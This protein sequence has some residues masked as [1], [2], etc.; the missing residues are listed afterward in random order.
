MTI[1]EAQEELRKI[2]YQWFDFKYWACMQLYARGLE[3]NGKEYNRRMDLA[4]QLHRV[5]EAEL[6]AFRERMDYEALK[7]EQA[8]ATCEEVNAF[9]R[10]Q[11]KELEKLV[12]AWRSLD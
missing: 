5:R 6:E 11:D 3:S 7:M 10:S 2:T 1:S 4:V 8:G 9:Y 12:S